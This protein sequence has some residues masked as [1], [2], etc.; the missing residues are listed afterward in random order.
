MNYF[1]LVIIVIIS[2]NNIN[3]FLSSTLSSNDRIT[4]LKYPL[5]LKRNIYNNYYNIKFYTIN[6]NINTYN[7]NNYKDSKSISASDDIINTN[8]VSFVSRIYKRIKNI[9]FRNRQNNIHQKIDSNN[10]NNNANNDYDSMKNIASIG[11]SNF[12]NVHDIQNLNYNNT[13]VSSKNDNNNDVNMSISDNAGIY[14]TDNI[15]DNYDDDDDVVVVT[16]LVNSNDDDSSSKNNINFHRVDNNNNINTSDN[17]FII[18]GDSY[19]DGLPMMLTYNNIQ[20]KSRVG[21]ELDKG[22]MKD[23]NNDN[24]NNDVHDNYND[25]D[26]NH[27]NTI[28]TEI[29]IIGAGISGLSC[30]NTLNNNNYSDYLIIESSSHVGGRVQTDKHD[31]GYLL[32]CG[33]QV[34]IDSYPEAI[35]V[36]NY[37]EL[38]LKPFLPGDK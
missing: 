18:D 1:L 4:Y 36:F 27:V 25:D 10:N 6:N 34:F 24:D 29:A 37:T 14:K 3:C 20:N 17:D 19:N 9:F 2:I 35:R 5:Y 28:H 22:N 8:K 32:D 13:I 11:I 31:D 23:D 7:N 38:Q 21:I 33:F 15:D 16:A 26:S 30:G 12:N